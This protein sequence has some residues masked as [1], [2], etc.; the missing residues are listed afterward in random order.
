MFKL[1]VSMAFLNNSPT[2]HTGEAGTGPPDA[3]NLQEP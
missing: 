1:L 3:N 2:Q